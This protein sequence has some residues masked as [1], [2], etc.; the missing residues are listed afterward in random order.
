MC[1]PQSKKIVIVGAGNVASHLLRAFRN[2]GAR[3]CIWA[4]DPRKA[5]AIA[6]GAE[7]CVAA[8]DIPRDADFYIVAVRDD[9]VADVVRA[10][11]AVDGIVA[12]TSGSVPVDAARAGGAA[13]AGVFYPLQTFSTNRSLDIAG[14]PFFI[15]ATDEATAAALGALARS[16]GATDYRADSSNRAVL[17]LAAVVACNFANALWGEAQKILETAGYSINV[18]APLLRE[19]LDKAMTIGPVQAQTGPAARND[20]EVIKRQLQSLDNPMMKQLYS[21]LTDLIK[22][23][24]QNKL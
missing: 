7:V 2:T 20:T 8:A 18:F 13:H 4:R 3:C 12:H 19:T 5:A 17:H 6:G 10:L 22:Y 23:Q 15:E 16:I 1:S 11:G 24:Q 9:A 21:G 14:A